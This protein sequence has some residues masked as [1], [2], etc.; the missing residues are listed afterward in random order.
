MDHIYSL[1]DF[2]M[3]TNALQGVAMIFGTSSLKNLVSG[4][5][6]LG[7]LFICTQYLVSQKFSPNH[8]LTGFVVYSVLFIPTTTVSVEDAYTNQVRTVANVPIGVAAPMAL[9][10]TMGLRMA[11]MFET[12]FSV[13]TQ[14]SMVE[15]G[16]M[17]ALN[18][19]LKMRS[20]G[21]GTA[22]TDGTTNTDV[23]ETLSSYMD[24]CVM[25]A[26]LTTLIVLT[27]L[28]SRCMNDVIFLFLIPPTI[29]PCL[30]GNQPMLRVVHQALMDA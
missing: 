8:L 3:L 15:N 2:E 1:G 12:A 14:A 25:F 27:F 23:A 13:P 21:I 5:F 29:K 30:S 9:V 11:Q 26:F 17:D 18:T 20:E 28:P 10:S 16:Y 6:V 19:L 4:G 22:G 7:M 24:T